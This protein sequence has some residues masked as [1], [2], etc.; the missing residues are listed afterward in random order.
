[1]D[2]LFLFTQKKQGCQSLSVYI[3]VFASPLRNLI[4]FDDCHP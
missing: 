4:S 1:M 3:L 2:V